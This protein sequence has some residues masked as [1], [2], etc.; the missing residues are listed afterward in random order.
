MSL[1][2]VTVN[3]KS[4]QRRQLGQR[5]PR[6]QKLVQVRP[7]DLVAAVITGGYPRFSDHQ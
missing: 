1:Y 2:F 7:C 5:V 4:R 3:Q 6:Y